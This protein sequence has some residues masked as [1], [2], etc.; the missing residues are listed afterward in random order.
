M[1]KFKKVHE[2]ERGE[3]CVLTDEDWKDLKEITI[4]TTWAG[5]ARGG[6][7]HDMHDEICLVVEGRIEY[8]MRGFM[9]ILDKGDR[10]LVPSGVPH[11]FKSLTDSTV[12]EYGATPEE[13]QVKDPEVRQ[14]V[15]EI[16][17][18]RM[19]RK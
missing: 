9:E 7:I 2:D 17:K 4:L 3:I 11:Y 12:I 18:N 13:K 8:H 10:T 19:E 5:F 14:L 1:I 6:S 16:N 15:D